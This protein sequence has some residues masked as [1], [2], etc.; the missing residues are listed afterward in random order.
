MSGL[1]LLA[2][3]LLTAACEPRNAAPG[4][5]AQLAQFDSLLADLGGEQTAELSRGQRWRLIASVGTGLPP[6]SYRLE[7]LPEPT[8]RAAALQQAYCLQC[9]GFSSPRMHTADEWPIL[10][11]RM[12]M[13]AAAL[14]SRLGGPMTEG[15]V[16]RML[17]AGLR[18][19]VLPSAE[20][21]DSLVAYFSR[22]ALPAADPADIDGGPD[23]RLFV[24]KCSG[25]HQTPS[26]QAHGPEDAQALVGRM[27]AMMAMLGMEPLSE[28]HKSRIVA[29][30]QQSAQ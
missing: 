29:F 25:C 22:N 15:M 14:K 21:T 9:H 8:S 30:L 26:P 12:I 4:Q 13:R 1:C 18:T 23:A 7:D 27:S 20:D 6:A 10:I 5:E 28:E 3:A 2:A 19:A 17:L 24:E 11:R 16:D